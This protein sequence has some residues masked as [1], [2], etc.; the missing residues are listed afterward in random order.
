MQ[1]NPHCT[2]PS[3]HHKGS[4]VKETVDG[5][6][7]QQLREVSNLGMFDQ[8]TK[9][10]KARSRA[11]DIRELELKAREELVNQR[12]QLL[13][14][15]AEDPILKLLEQTRQREEENW[16]A[17]WMVK[18]EEWLVEGDDKEQVEKYG[19]RYLQDNH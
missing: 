4:E 6:L 2:A 15:R 11:L 18:V 16:D 9:E 13:K 19:R 8:H 1:K 17:A 7:A 12:R 10:L 14:K 5:A 3:F